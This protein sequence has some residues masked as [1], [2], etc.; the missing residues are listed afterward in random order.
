MSAMEVIELRTSPP[1]P[2][3]PCGK[4]GEGNDDNSS[5]ELGDMLERRRRR[6]VLT[7]EEAAEAIGISIRSYHRY[8]NGRAPGIY[9]A[10]LIATW[11]DVT[12]QEIVSRN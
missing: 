6:Q 3:S 12:V 1:Q 11:L 9:Q 10:R 8:L 7:Q 4:R 5:S 2:P